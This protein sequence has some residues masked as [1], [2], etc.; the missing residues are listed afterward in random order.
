MYYSAFLSLLLLNCSSRI[1]LCVAD[2]DITYPLQLPFPA[3]S[4][5]VSYR[6][7]FCGQDR[8]IK[9][10]ATALRNSVSG[11]NVSVF[12]LD[13]DPVFQDMHSYRGLLT[14][15]LDEVARRAG[16]SW[17]QLYSVG[18]LETTGLS[19]Y[20]EL[21]EWSTDHYDISASRW[22]HQI[23]AVPT[24]ARVHYGWYQES[25]V[26]VEIKTTQTKKIN[27]LD[28]MSPFDYSVWALIGATI[29]FSAITYY[30]LIV[31]NADTEEEEDHGEMR[32]VASLYIAAMSFTNNFDFHP[33]S[34]SVKLWSFSIAFWA[35]IISAAYTANLA[36]FLVIRN[37][38]TVA[39]TS[40]SAICTKQT[41]TCVLTGDFS[42]QYFT[43][44][45]SNVEL[46][47]K[48]DLDSMIIGLKTGECDAAV[49]GKSTYEMMIR[50]K[51]NNDCILTYVDT[52]TRRPSGFAII[53]DPSKCTNNLGNVLE[54]YFVDMEVDGFTKK[55]LD[56]YFLNMENQNCVPGPSSANS[57]SGSS[58]LQ[59]Y[60]VVGIFA[61]HALLSITALCMALC[62]FTFK[63]Y[64]G[65]INDLP[66][67]S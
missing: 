43:G 26:V 33:V 63:K 52:L 1:F 54:L 37:K 31:L 55:T 34:I 60:D 28:F 67:Q 14:E 5:N 61:L 2:E 10:N 20:N 64:R 44:A 35:L 45:Y 51:H 9:S 36:S 22:S 48:S 47:S 39:V 53:S 49:V 56:R 30:I 18:T 59:V 15:L 38:S 50:S 19:N 4:S 42:E 17:R 29:L 46:I 57:N 27:Y 40:L 58:K 21:L 65:R 11:Q 16:F 24:A 3:T 25:L 41:P 23:N 32:V 13:E 62:K 66:H 6:H 12:I 8:Q 7:N